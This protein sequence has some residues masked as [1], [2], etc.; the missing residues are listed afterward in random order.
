MKKLRIILILLITMMNILQAEVPGWVNRVLFD[1]DGNEIWEM[2]CDG[3]P[4]ENFRMPAVDIEQAR[5]RREV[6]IIDDVPTFDWC[7]GCANTSAAMM[8]GY[9][10]RNGYSHMYAGPANGGVCPLTNL[11]WGW[12]ESPLSA[13]HQGYDGLN[14]RGH[15]NDYYVYAGYE[16]EDPWMTGGWVPHDWADCTGD[17]MG[18]SQYN[19]GASDGATIFYFRADGSRLSEVPEMGGLRERDGCTGMANFVLSRDYHASNYYTSATGGISYFTF[20]DYM[21]E[22]DAGRPVLIFV[23][24]AT[25][26]H[27]MLGIGY[28]SFLN[29][30]YIHDTWD[31]STHTMDWN[32][33]YSGMEMDAV[34]CLTLSTNVVDADFEVEDVQ[35]A[36]PFMVAFED[37]SSGYPTDYEWDF[38]N[39][40]TIDSE[41]R[42][43]EWTYTASGIY[44]VNLHAYNWD[45]DDSI[46]RTDYIIVNNPPNLNLPASFG[47][48]SGN[49]LILDVGEYSSDA[50]GDDYTLSVSGMQNLI[51]DQ[52]GLVL[53]ITAPENYTGSEMLEF[54]LDDGLDITTSECMIM[55]YPAG[56]AIVHVPDDYAT[57]QEAI[58]A[59]GHGYMVIVRP[60]T[61]H[62][63]IELG[64]Y[65]IRVGSMYLETGN[66]AYIGQTVLYGDGDDVVTISEGNIFQEFTGFKITHSSGG[67]GIY[68]EERPV[69]VHHLIINYNMAQE[70]SGIYIEG[71]TPLIEY[72]SFYQNYLSGDGGTIYCHNAQPVLRNLTFYNNNGDTGTAILAQT[73]S[74]VTGVN[75][76]VW[77]NEGESL[78]CDGS[79]EINISYSNLQEMQG[80]EGIIST[81]PLFVD[82]GNFNLHLQENSACIDSGDPDTDGDGIEWEADIDDQD[83]DGTRKDMGA[84]PYNQNNSENNDVIAAGLS[85]KIYPNPFNMDNS[86]NE[87]KICYGLE[88]SVDKAELEIYNIRGQLIKRLGI[89]GKSGIVTWDGRDEPDRLSGSGV[90]LVRLRS[91]EQEVTGK[92]LIIK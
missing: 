28:D 87:I 67:S 56:G 66:E 88:S 14:V 22:I 74:I 89:S 57:I 24:D 48:E 16:G 82:A 34:C 37:L 27:A 25:S 59:A 77:A 21:T 40:G 49:S 50:D 3:R 29:D 13:T 76:I 43:P 46:T 19:L 38:D 26:G 7:Y 64:D 4:P 52:E 41:E 55:V 73:N 30:I 54:S 20:I 6:V 68:L 78:A 90:Y 75:L 86:R 10:D 69:Y 91:A 32:G 45:T 5:L 8:M 36:P 17:Y 15:V 79:S 62:E 2:I 11:V 1:E 83:A 44:S 23:S 39:N 71:G 65:E 51:V 9:Y 60:G 80:G 31:W 61:Y 12:G 63:N 92:F 42:F 85:L 72:V 81:D 58:D 33:E 18:T 84:L 47:F 70:G 35:G 53:E